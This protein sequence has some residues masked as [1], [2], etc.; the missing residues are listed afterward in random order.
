MPPLEDSLKR[1]VLKHLTKIR[2]SDP[3]LAFRKRHGSAFTTAGDPDIHGVW[4]GVPFDIELKQPGEEPTPLQAAR[5]R[6][7]SYAGSITGVA[8]SLAEFRALMGRVKH[9]ISVA[10]G[11]N[12]PV[13]GV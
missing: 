13:R 3:T 6:E 1:S 4:H 12:T 11:D 5:L 9:S 7:W 8:H 10:A 2:A